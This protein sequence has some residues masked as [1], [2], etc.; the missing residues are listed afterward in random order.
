MVEVRRTHF[1]KKEVPRSR[2]EQV[3]ATGHPLWAE[4]VGTIGIIG[5][6]MKQLREWAHNVQTHACASEVLLV[7]ILYC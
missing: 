2:V 6:L 5:V 1:G 4:Q 7:F 3:M